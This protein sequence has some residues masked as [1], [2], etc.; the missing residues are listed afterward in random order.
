MADQAAAVPTETVKIPRHRSP[1]YPSMGLRA[2]VGKVETLYKGGAVNPLM[3]ISVLKI[4]GYDKMHGE[5]GRVVSALK[6]FGLIEETKDDR[7]KLSQRGLDIAARQPGELRRIEAIRQAATGPAIY[8]DLLQEYNGKLPPDG[9]L[10]S[11]LIAAKHFNPNAVDGFISDLK[12]TLDFAGLSDVAVLNSNGKAASHEDSQDWEPPSE[13]ELPKVGDFIQWESQGVLQFSEPKRVRALSPDAEW[14]FVE[15]SETGLP[16]KEV[17]VES[18]AP[19]KSDVKPS[20]T[21]PV[22]PLPTV[23]AA[24]VFSWPLSK[25]VTAE[26]K[27]TGTSITPAHLELLRSYLE[28]AKQALQLEEG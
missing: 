18:P 21:P 6:G 28:L 13:K 14:V 4:L 23:P 11:Q 15:D 3:R 8:K 17:T 9:A 7:I 19:E 16:V 22:L 1:N 10:K 20:V 12:D 27:L 26:V 2:A 24:K 25:G 5:A